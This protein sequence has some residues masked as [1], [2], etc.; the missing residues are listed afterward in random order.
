MFNR[1]RHWWR[2]LT[3][4]PV[5]IIGKV[6]QATSKP[7]VCVHVSGLCGS[8]GVYIWADT[9]EGNARA[10]LYGQGLAR[11]MQRRLIDTRPAK[12]R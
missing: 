5:V 2:R 4:P 3:N 6:A 7:K 9:E 1:V 8:Q 10:T 11:I 12:T